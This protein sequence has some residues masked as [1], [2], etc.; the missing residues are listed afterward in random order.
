MGLQSSVGITVGVSA[1]LPATLDSTG[2]G[3]LTM[4][5]GGKLS[6]PPPMS[7]KKD[8]ATFDNLS[9]GEEEKLVDMLRAG[10]GDLVFGYDETDAGQTILGTAA[11]ASTDAGSKVA[12]AFT[13]NSGTIFYRLAIIT[14]HTPQ[15]SVG[16]VLT[17]TCNCEFYRKHVKV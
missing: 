7:G 12:L 15:G 4:T 10:S 5:S 3:A 8:V 11:D 17:A 6:A 9:T 13:L 14:S 2:F 1:T 16:N